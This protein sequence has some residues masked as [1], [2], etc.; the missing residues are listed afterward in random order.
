MLL[1]TLTERIILREVSPS[2][3]V[4]EMRGRGYLQFARRQKEE[5]HLPSR[6]T[7]I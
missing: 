3:I 1:C 7:L 4:G 6:V 2:A 5:R